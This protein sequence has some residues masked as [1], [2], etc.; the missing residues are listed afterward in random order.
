ME[1]R[2]AVERIDELRREI[3]RIDRELVA[4]FEKRMDTALAIGSIKR[5]SG[6][7]IKNQNREEQVKA[8]CRAGC[9]NKSYAPYAEAVMERVMDACREIQYP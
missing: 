2:T 6:M 9:K 4:L 7:D 8:N 1:Q 5:E 3:D